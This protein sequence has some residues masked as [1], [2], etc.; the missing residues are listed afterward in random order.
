MITSPTVSHP[1]QQGGNE[2]RDSGIVVPGLIEGGEGAALL[3]RESP[4]AAGS[5]GPKRSICFLQLKRGTWHNQKQ[6][7]A[8]LPARPPTPFLDL[9]EHRG[10]LG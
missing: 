6:L 1:P 7:K 2:T 9:G 8:L 10:W 4:E 5:L 3:C